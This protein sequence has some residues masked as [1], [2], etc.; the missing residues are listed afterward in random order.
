MARGRRTSPSAARDGAGTG[1]H[2]VPTSLLKMVIERDPDGVSIMDKSLRYLAVNAAWI[3]ATGVGEPPIGRTPMEVF[4]DTFG[5]LTREFGSALAGR[6]VIKTFRAGQDGGLRQII[7]TPW[8]DEFGEIGGV[9]TRRPTKT[10]A[11]RT[12]VGTERRLK[13]AME[14]A[15]SPF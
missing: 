14:M 2:F 3:S 9:V 6:E 15:K 11:L 13:V 8:R 4:G 7:M 1:P 12:S 10:T 5:N